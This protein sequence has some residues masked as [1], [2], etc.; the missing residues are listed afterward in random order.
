MD[1]K[2]PTLAAEVYAQLGRCDALPLPRRFPPQPHPRASN[3]SPA[4]CFTVFSSGRRRYR[5]AL[6]KTVPYALYRWLFFLLLICLFSLRVWYAQ[7][8]TV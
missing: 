2:A 5:H 1:P 4:P 6:D 3:C 7:G 8:Q